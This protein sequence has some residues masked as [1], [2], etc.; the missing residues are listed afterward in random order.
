MRKSIK[1]LALVVGTLLLFSSYGNIRVKAASLN[2]GIFEEKVV[3]E[4]IQLYS[5]MPVVD[6]NE[7]MHMAK[8]GVDELCRD[9]GI[10]WNA[11]IT[12]SDLCCDVSTYC[13]SQLIGEYMYDN[14]LFKEYALTSLAV[15]DVKQYGYAPVSGQGCTLRTTMVVTWNASGNRAALNYQA[16]WV[17]GGNPTVLVMENKVDKGL[18][19]GKS[20]VNSNQILGPNGTYTLLTPSSEEVGDSYGSEL[21]CRGTVYFQGGSSIVSSVILDPGGIVPPEI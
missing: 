4:K 15:S 6:T 19:T 1:L 12:A 3:S 20:Y 2:N 17:T 10:E 21:W 11:E 14:E 9:T 5:R 7:L 8:F 13:T 16:T 18:D